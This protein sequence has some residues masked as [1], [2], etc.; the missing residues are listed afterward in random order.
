MSIR[1]YLATSLDGYVAG[2]DDDLS[3]LPTDVDLGEHGFAPF[4]AEIG[5]IL[6]GDVSEARWMQQLIDDKRPPTDDIDFDAG[7]SWDA[8]EKVADS[9]AVVSG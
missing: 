6:M 1:A 7:G 3:W 9:I 2:P 4:F 5:A 8:D